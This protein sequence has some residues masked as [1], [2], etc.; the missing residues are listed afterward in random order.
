MEQK[1]KSLLMIASGNLLITSAYTLFAMPN[2]IVDGGITSTALLLSHYLNSNLT[3]TICFLTFFILMF[4]YITMGK[5]F[6][7]KTLYSS[8]CYISFFIFFN[9]TGVVIATSTINSLL[10]AGVLIGLGHY[11]CLKENSSTIGY[12]VIALFCHKV[13]KKCSTTT[14]LWIICSAILLLGANFFG[15]KIIITGIL[16]VF[17]ETQIIY[18]CS[19]KGREI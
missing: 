17:I 5:Y 6:F 8:L 15:I 3:Y 12:D 10:I 7:L 11:L 13:N 19:D 16:F 1:I 18:W 9:W 4:S 2:N 14:I